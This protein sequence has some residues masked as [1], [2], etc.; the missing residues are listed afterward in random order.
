[1]EILYL[2]MLQVSILLSSVSV[3]GEFWRE[4]LLHSFTQNYRFFFGWDFENKI[5]NSYIGNVTSYFRRFNH[6]CRRILPKKYL[7]S[8]ISI[9]CHRTLDW[10]F[11]YKIS[12]KGGKFMKNFILSTYCFYQF[13]KCLMDCLRFKQNASTLSEIQKEHYREMARHTITSLHEKICRNKTKQHRG[14]KKP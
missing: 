8:R 6:S 7:G 12:Q 4:S 1:M 2:F 11:A 5:Q 10:D 13:F 3:F 14:I 9:L